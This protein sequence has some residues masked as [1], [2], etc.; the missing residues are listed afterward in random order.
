MALLGEL[1]RDGGRPLVM[2]THHLEEIPQ[3]ITHAVLLRSGRIVAAGPIADT[4][5]SEAVSDTFGLAVVVDTDRRRY[6][7]R[8]APT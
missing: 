7:A 1:A 8:V 6:S 3:G 5:T 4:L 2:V